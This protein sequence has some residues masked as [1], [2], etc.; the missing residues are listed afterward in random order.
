[1]NS[2]TKY[3][4]PL[5]VMYSCRI[6]F[7][8]EQ[9]DILKNAHIK[10]RRQFATPEQAPVMKGSSVSVLTATEAPAKS[11]QAFGLSSIVTND[12]IC[13]RETVPLVVALN[14]QEMLG[15]K[16]IDRKFLDK[17]FAGY[18]DHCFSQVV[19]S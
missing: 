10:F 13:S 1:M 12:L 6:R 8:D 7:T 14:L 9:R 5:P 11:Y 4:G 17:Q 16:V 18:L 2:T 15:V 3:N 19:G